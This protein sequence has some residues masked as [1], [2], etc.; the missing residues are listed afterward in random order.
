MTSSIV[1]GARIV[2]AGLRGGYPQAVIKTVD[3]SVSGSTTLQ[4][5]DELFTGVAASSAYLF[6][7]YLDYEAGFSGGQGFLQYKWTVPTGATLR[8]SALGTTVLAAV[9]AAT[10]QK[11]T[12]AYTLN[13]S[14]AGTL[15]AAS[16]IGTLVTSATAGILQLQWA[17][18]ISSGTAT[19]VHAQSYLALWKIS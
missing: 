9:Q 4:N 11:E 1:T 13:G 5:D 10:T 15:L 12:T 7:C 2:A 19:K 14:G 16:M 3:E 8:F 6:A 17:Q 18:S